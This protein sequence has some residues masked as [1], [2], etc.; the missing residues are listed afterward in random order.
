MVCRPTPNG[1][2]QKV[3]DRVPMKA[4][5][6][7]FSS[8][9]PRSRLIYL[10]N[11]LRVGETEPSKFP[12][13]IVLNPGPETLG[14]TPTLLSLLSDNVNAIRQPATRKDQYK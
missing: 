9:Q 3:S 11:R 5:G 13:D 8:I 14:E 2:H 6:S 4:L 7:L 12:P 10:D 1:F